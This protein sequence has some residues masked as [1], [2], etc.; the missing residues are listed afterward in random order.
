MKKANVKP[1]ELDLVSLGTARDIWVQKIGMQL[2]T[3]LSSTKLIQIQLDLSK[4]YQMRFQVQS[5]VLQAKKAVIAR[6]L[7]DRGL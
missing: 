7:E 4:S 3:N 2:D 6:L 1:C 5:Q